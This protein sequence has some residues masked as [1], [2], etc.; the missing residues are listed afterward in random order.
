MA[1][2][3]VFVD[4]RGSCTEGRPYQVDN[5]G[6]RDAL[7]ELVFWLENCRPSFLTSSSGPPFQASAYQ[8]IIAHHR[9]LA[10]AFRTQTSGKQAVFYIY[11]K[12]LGHRPPRSTSPPPD[13][14][15]ADAAGGIKPPEGTAPKPA[16]S[17]LSRHRSKKNGR[18]G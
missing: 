10:T 8:M 9:S 7:W 5:L 16:D 2:N 3:S 12:C 4:C 14:H 11:Q 13:R 1:L 6:W 17:L 15:M 18:A